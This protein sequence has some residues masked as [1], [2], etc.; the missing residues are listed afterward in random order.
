MNRNIDILEQ[1]L[2]HCRDVCSDVSNFGDSEEAF[3]NNLAYWRSVFFSLFMIGEQAYSLTD[4]YV[5]LT[6]KEMNWK[7]IKGLRNLIVHDYGNVRQDAIWKTIKEDIPVLTEFCER[8]INEA[9]SI[10][11]AAK[12]MPTMTL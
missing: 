8:K 6:S 5:A 1:I 3:L 9:D 12:N 11:R 2:M 7:A 10:M 4:C